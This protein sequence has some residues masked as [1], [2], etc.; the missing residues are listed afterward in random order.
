VNKTNPS[1]DDDLDS[2]EEILQRDIDTT[3]VINE[4]LLTTKAYLKKD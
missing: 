4:S 2:D 1:Y 3:L